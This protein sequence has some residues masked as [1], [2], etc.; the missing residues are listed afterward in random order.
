M[1][2]GLYPE[3]YPSLDAGKNFQIYVFVALCMFAVNYNNIY[4]D[5]GITQHQASINKTKSQ[6]YES[7]AF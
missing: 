6:A 7:L 2:R 5:I 1:K 3:F 4:V